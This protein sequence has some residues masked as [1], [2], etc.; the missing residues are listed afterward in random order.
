MDREFEILNNKLNFIFE[1]L[2]WLKKDLKK[3]EYDKEMKELEYKSK[4]AQ[5]EVNYKK[6]DIRYACEIIDDR[7]KYFR[8]IELNY[9]KNE[10]NCERVER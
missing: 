10:M 1:E 5:E 4:Q 3:Y 8:N 6:D 2:M 7:M 9:P